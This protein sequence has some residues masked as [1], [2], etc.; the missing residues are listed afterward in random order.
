MSKK[1]DAIAKAEAK[2]EKAELKREEAKEIAKEDAAAIKKA[3]YPK[4][5]KFIKLF[6]GS[7]ETGN[8]KH[9]FKVY[10]PEMRAAL[11][12]KTLPE[13]E[14]ANE[15]VYNWLKKFGVLDA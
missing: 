9:V 6:E 10:K 7:L 2:E 12:K 13:R 5:V 15:S 14:V 4:K 8:E 3:A 1:E 11:E